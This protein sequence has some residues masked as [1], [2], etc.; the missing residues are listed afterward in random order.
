MRRFWKEFENCN[1]CIYPKIIKDILSLC[2]IDQATFGDLTEHSI[3][4]VEKIVNQNKS[5]LKN[6]VYASV[7]DKNEEFKF[8]F[9]H[10]L[11]LLTLTS[12][13]IELIC[14]KKAFRQIHHKCK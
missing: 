1:N 12:S 5:V 2:A 11:I 7:Y 14:T 9:G 4:E 13:Y 8:L 3:E 6:S 10:R